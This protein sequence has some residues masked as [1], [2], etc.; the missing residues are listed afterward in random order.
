MCKDND[1]YHVLLDCPTILKK[2]SRSLVLDPIS[3]NL[4]LVLTAWFSAHHIILLVNWATHHRH[5]DGFCLPLQRNIRF[6]VYSKGIWA[7][8][9]SHFLEV[10]TLDNKIE[11]DCEL[12]VALHFFFHWMVCALYLF[13]KFTINSHIIKL[14]GIAVLEY[15]V[16]SDIKDVPK[17]IFSS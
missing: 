12:R 4:V 15:R 3:Q 6:S 5:L 8:M 2:K 11:V 17:V 9:F 10:H 7:V 16:E 1:I 13:F 14:V